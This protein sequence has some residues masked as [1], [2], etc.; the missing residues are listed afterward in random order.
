VNVAR[1]RG[2][3]VFHHLAEVPGCASLPEPA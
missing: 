2:L 1:Q 3:A